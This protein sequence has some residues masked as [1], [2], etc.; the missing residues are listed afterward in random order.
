MQCAARFEHI[1]GLYP[2]SCIHRLSLHMT[3]RLR[4]LLPL[5]RFTF[6]IIMADNLTSLLADAGMPA[7]ACD[8]N[9]IVAILGVGI[10]LPLCLLR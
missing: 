6:Q 8:R 2:Q 4:P 10:L 3:L 9:N 7:W 1:S 5:C